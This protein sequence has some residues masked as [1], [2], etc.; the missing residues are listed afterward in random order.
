MKVPRLGNLTVTDKSN[1]KVSGEIV[2]ANKNNTS[3]CDL[4]FIHKSEGSD[5]LSYYKIF[6]V[7]SNPST[8]VVIG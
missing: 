5:L 8:S 7:E 3:D 6:S 2:C 4:Y 1:N